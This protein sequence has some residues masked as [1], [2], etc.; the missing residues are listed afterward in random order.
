MS[1][2]TEP[3]HFLK[4][5][6]PQHLIDHQ[7][8]GDGNVDHDFWTTLTF[9]QSL[10]GKIAG[11][12]GQQLILS[13]KESMLMTHWMRSIHDTILVGI[14]TVINDD[15]QLNTRHLPPR[16][17]GYPQP[18]PVILDTSLRLPLDCKLIRNAKIGMGRYPIVIC[19]EFHN[20]TKY[21][22]RIA[23]LTELGV[24]VVPLLLSADGRV[25]LKAVTETL[26]SLGYRSLMVEGGQKVISSYL[27]STSM[28]LVDRVI[29]TIAPV[30]LI[31]N[32]EKVACSSLGND[33]V[34][35]YIMIPPS[36]GYMNPQPNV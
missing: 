27:S 35:A 29:I 24:K 22:E 8:V 12:N 33:I 7:Q 4:Q 6:L 26:K 15:P 34:V 16:E 30:L 36:T 25:P 32:F 2:S 10:D 18:Q 21:Q 13:G 1:T 11:I 17:G 31:T 20:D 9:A 3:L 19:G 5:S 23:V 14:N 28:H